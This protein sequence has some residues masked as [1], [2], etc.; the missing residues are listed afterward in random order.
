[1]F[2]FRYPGS[3]GLHD[4][5][6]AVSARKHDQPY[7]RQVYVG[8]CHLG[9]HRSHWATGER[10]SYVVE[11]LQRCV[12]IREGGR[13]VEDVDPGQL[14]SVRKNRWKPASMSRTTSAFRTQMF[15]R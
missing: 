3:V 13:W 10:S 5:D 11:I 4:R 6:C 2:E 12:R 9:S 15:P 14:R 7:E 1:K 8:V